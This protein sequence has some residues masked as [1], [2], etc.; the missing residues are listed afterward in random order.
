MKVQT[1]VATALVVVSFL[2]AGCSG[3]NPP[4]E[5]AGKKVTIGQLE[6][7]PKDSS[8][9]KGESIIW[10]NSVSLTHTVTFDDESMASKSSGS[11]NKGAKHTVKF[12]TAGTYSYHCAIPGHAEKVGDKWT[13][14]TGNVT[15]SA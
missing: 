5:P 13:G 6:Y 14:M 10:E 8:V 3:S 1:L 2:I 15:V 11:M 4:A 12:D 7:T 9:K